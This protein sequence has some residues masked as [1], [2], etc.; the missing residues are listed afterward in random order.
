ML[1]FW[2][3]DRRGWTARAW[4]R[5]LGGPSPRAGQG[6]CQSSRCSGQTFSLTSGLLSSETQLGSSP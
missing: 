3:L 2:A 1:A 5:G 4:G 6:S